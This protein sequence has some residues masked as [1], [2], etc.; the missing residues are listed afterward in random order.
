MALPATARLAE[1]DAVLISHAHLDHLDLPSLL[2]LDP[3]PCVWSF[4][5]VGGHW[6]DGRASRT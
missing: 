1:P 3:V 5:E 6:Q 4:L 2:V